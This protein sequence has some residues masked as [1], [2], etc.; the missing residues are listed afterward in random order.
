ME[1]DRPRWY[2]MYSYPSSSNIKH[3]TRRTPGYSCVHSHSLASQILRL[4]S[5]SKF[6]PT[7]PEP[8]PKVTLVTICACVLRT[9]VLKI[10]SFVENAIRIWA[11]YRLYDYPNSFL[12]CFKT[13]ISLCLGRRYVYV[14]VILYGNGHHSH[15]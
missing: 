9:R 6:A 14:L 15:M 2:D 13:M 12:F 10:A 3:G 5:S 11:T 7:V 1:D 8:S 4:T